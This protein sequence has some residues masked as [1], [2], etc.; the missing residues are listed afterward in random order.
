MDP[1][2]ISRIAQ[3]RQDEIAERAKR[4]WRQAEPVSLREMISP[5]LDR[6]RAFTKV[7]R[8]AV[9]RQPTTP[10]RSQQ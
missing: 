6:V 8:P 3:I 10:A 5:L 7:A 9:R 4:D 1:I 2:T